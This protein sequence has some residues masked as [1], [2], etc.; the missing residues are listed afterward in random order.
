MPE[1]GAPRRLGLGLSNEAPVAET[2]ALA[3]QAEALGFSEVWLPESS[4]GRGLFT[5][6]ASVAA[7]TRRIQI[8]IGIVNPFWRHPSLI[9]MEAA[10]LDEASHGR[11]LLGVGAALW[12][13]RALG[14]ADGRTERPLSAMI[15]AL[16]VVRGLLRGEPGVDGQIFAVRGDAK[17]D[18]PRYRA[19]IPVYVG[20]VNGRMLRASGAWSDGVQLGAMVSPGYVRWSWQQIVRGAQ[21][22]GRDPADL[23]LAS[24]VLVSV[25][26]SPR[27]AR[28]A[29]RR[30][31]AYYI[32]RVEPIVLSTSGADPE[33][34][35]RV[36]LA[37]FESGVD[38]AA[39]LVTDDLIDVFA[40]AGDPEHVVAR[41]Q[42]YAAAGLRGIL[43]WHV[44]GPDRNQALRL[45]AD[46]VRPHVF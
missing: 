44:I 23:D 45:L 33:A 1:S 25:D 5:V 37:V 6:A 31:L 29:V 3:Q 39:C 4:H 42:D 10:A 43:A 24:N 27:A 40:A 8:G 19:S 17:L 21:A 11:L 9:A 36:R 26:R 35:E 12:T 46:E 30:V 15:E 32:H 14:E 2:V 13:L 38:A 7:A 41:L 18:F 16:R 34:I 20:A 22:A 28:D